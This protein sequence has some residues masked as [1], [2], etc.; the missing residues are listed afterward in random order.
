[1]SSLSCDARVGDGDFDSLPFLFG[2]EVGVS[3][4]DA[5]SGV[6]ARLEDTPSTLNRC[7]SVLEVA[8]SA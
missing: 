2:V 7:A 4:V 3:D 1:M 8:N 5:V 6:P